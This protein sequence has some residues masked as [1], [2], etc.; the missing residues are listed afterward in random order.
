MKRLCLGLFCLLLLCCFSSMVQANDYKQ[1]Y[2][3]SVVPGA[4]SG[5]GMSAQY[6]ADLVKAKSQNRINIKVYCNSQ[7]MAGMQTSE[8]LLTQ[9]FH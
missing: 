6:F 1:E 2:K 4:T 9:W 7:L 8:F 5:W 3:L